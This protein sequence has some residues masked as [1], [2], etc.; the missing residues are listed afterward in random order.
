MAATGT[1]SPDAVGGAI[2]TWVPESAALDGAAWVCD[3]ESERVSKRE[4]K[5]TTEKREGFVR[6]AEGLRP[7]EWVVISPEN[8]NDGQRVN[9]TLKQP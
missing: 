1:T 3:P 9:P 4:I 5:T 6:V 8:L 7:G 2:A